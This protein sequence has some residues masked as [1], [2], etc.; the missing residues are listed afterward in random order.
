MQFSIFDVV[1]Q[2]A[3][4]AML[5][6]CFGTILNTIA[7]CNRFENDFKPL[8]CRA[9]HVSEAHRL[10]RVIDQLPICRAFWLKRL[11]DLFTQ[12]NSYK[13]LRE[14]HSMELCTQSLDDLLPVVVRCE[15]S[16]LREAYAV[17]GVKLAVMHNLSV[18]KPSETQYRDRNYKN[19]IGT[20]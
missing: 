4:N 17:T 5:Q 7:S 9:T 3:S 18:N 11:G 14:L 2:I 13:R 10:L 1:V 15:A 12:I 6:L 8:N 19:A 20:D 16:A